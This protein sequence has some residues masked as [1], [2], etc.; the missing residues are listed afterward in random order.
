[1]DAGLFSERSFRG[2][3]CTAGDFQAY[4]LETNVEAIA[5]TEDQRRPN[6]L[7][8]KARRWIA[9]NAAEQAAKDVEWFDVDRLE[10]LD[11]ARKAEQ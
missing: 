3:H 9:E 5:F 1:M 8:E 6:P 7:A 4:G 10:L 2:W 11:L